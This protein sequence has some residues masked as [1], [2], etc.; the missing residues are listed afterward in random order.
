MAAFQGL[1]FGFAEGTQEGVKD[2]IDGSNNRIQPGRNF[3]YNIELGDE[4]GSLRWHTT[5][6]WAAAT[7]HAPT[8]AEDDMIIGDEIEEI[9]LDSNLEQ[10]ITNAIDSRFLLQLGSKFDLS[11]QTNVLFGGI[12]AASDPHNEGPDDK[13]VAA[14]T[15]AC[16]FLHWRMDAIETIKLAG[17]KA[18][19]VVAELAKLSRRII[20]KG[21]RSFP[22][23][24]QRIGHNT[25]PKEMNEVCNWLTARL[26][27]EG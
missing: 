27:L 26:G 24:P 12:S 1:R 6:A 2:T 23:L 18:K 25:I 8:V 22:L 21:G 11:E 14:V 3:T 9:V 7:L 13:E 10:Q 20:K 15:A 16:A 17:K 4:I 5:S 19:L